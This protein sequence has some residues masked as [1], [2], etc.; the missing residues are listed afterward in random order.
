MADK[1]KA[2]VI[3]PEPEVHLVGEDVPGPGAG[4]ALDRRIKE[5]EAAVAEGR[6]F[7]RDLDVNDSVDP[8]EE[9]EE[10]FERTL[11]LE[12]EDPSEQL[13]QLLAA[14]A[15]D[16]PGDVVP[17]P[18]VETPDADQ[19][20]EDEDEPGPEEA[21]G[22]EAE[23]EEAEEEV[24]VLAVPGRQPGDPDIEIE[25]EGLDADQREAFQRMR[26]GYMRKEQLH[27]E[28]AAF[29]KRAAAVDEFVVRLE[30][31]PLNVVMA[32]LEA[33][34]RVELA[35]H[36]L[37][38]EAVYGKVIDEIAQWDRNPDKR[39]AAQAE[40]RL[41]RREAADAADRSIGE[42]RAARESVQVIRSAVT[43]LIP[44]GMG[45]DE[46]RGF[47]E[48]AMYD[49]QRHANEN[50]LNRMSAEQVVDVL[51]KSGAFRRYGI[52]RADAERT[53]ASLNATPTETPARARAKPRPSEEAD[54]EAKARTAGERLR[55]RAARRRVAATTPRG[56][57]SPPARL[58]M[59]KG[60]GV[61][62]RA[63]WFLKNR[64]GRG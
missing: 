47:W 56:A 50:K 13:R 31:D 28:R 62:E 10:T 2:A 3:V 16:K 1:K 30:H 53:V 19:E 42:T 25:L 9:E 55:S 64:A 41:A 14:Q 49:L 52:S 54:R 57:G 17:E 36:L 48:S 21:E 23:G 63:E 6:E 11:D 44:E 43:S 18:E 12:V 38:D 51:D 8:F 40:L 61:E 22:E 35:R 33:D 24:F 37:A 60:Q 58:Q 26:N 4:T 32:E 7:T 15:A 46:A 39:A 5:V 29:E 59:P 20:Q 27:Q 34:T 45:E